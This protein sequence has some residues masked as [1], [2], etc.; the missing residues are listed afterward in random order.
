MKERELATANIKNQYKME[1]EK[2]KEILR[3]HNI[4]SRYKGDIENSPE[5]LNPQEVG[6]AIDTVIEFLDKTV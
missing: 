2:A 5:M 1:I 4:W 6:K 3:Q